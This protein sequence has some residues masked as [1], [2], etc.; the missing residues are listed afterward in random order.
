MTHVSQSEVPC[1]MDEESGVEL[2][3]RRF[4]RPHAA[5]KN[6]ADPATSE[7]SSRMAV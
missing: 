6:S 1:E 5:M 3:I 7:F 4:G 2:Q